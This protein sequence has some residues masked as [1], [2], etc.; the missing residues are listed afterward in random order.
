METRLWVLL[1]SLALVVSKQGR[2]EKK[3]LETRLG[4]KA[5]TLLDTFLQAGYLE[6][7]E[8]GLVRPGWRTR[9][10]LDLQ[11]IMML[12]TPSPALVM[13]PSEQLAVKV[14]DLFIKCVTCNERIILPWKEKGQAKLRRGISVDCPHCQNHNHTSYDSFKG[15]ALRITFYDPS[16]TKRPEKDK[17]G[18]SAPVVPKKAESKDH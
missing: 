13:S 16:K 7:D 12:H 11:S 18:Q 5:L 14:D 4:Q 15:S 3:E 17:R 6:E 9:A 10:E 8:K 1:A 2:C